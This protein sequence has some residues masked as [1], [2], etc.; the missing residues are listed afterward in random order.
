MVIKIFI[1]KIQQIFSGD[2]RQ[3][4]V[5]E[6]SSLSWQKKLATFLNKTF[7]R[8]YG[9]QYQTE[10]IAGWIKRCPECFTVFIQKKI[11]SEQIVATVKILP[12]LADPISNSKTFDSYAVKPDDL[13]Q[14]I[15]SAQAIWIGDLVSTDQNFMLLML[16]ITKATEG[17]SIP[18]Y[19][20]T[21]VSKLH[22]VLLKRYGAILIES[23]SE[24]DDGASVF[25][26]TAP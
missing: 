5:H 8:D 10:Q 25:L 18:V 22:H 19:C 20:R 7:S 21:K 14:D 24:K 15:H 23:L 26:L 2:V 13:A 1:Q 6:V 9:K 17:L 11:F 16:T 4:S 3:L 12:L